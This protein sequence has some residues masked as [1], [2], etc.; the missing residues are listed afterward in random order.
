M[1]DIEGLALEAVK[2]VARPAVE[3]AG[4]SVIGWL[5]RRF[6]SEKGVIEAVDAVSTD[7]NSIAAKKILECHLHLAM[8][9]CPRFVEEL[10]VFLDQPS[11]TS[12]TQAARVYG[13]GTIKQ[14]QGNNNRA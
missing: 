10:R 1:S 5:R 12:P 8:E 4:K 9:K 3:E 13:S 11:V 7:P 6:K 2:L 14:I